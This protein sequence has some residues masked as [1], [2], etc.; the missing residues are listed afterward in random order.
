MF[1]SALQKQRVYKVI[2]LAKTVHAE[3]SKR[4]S[5]NKLNKLLL[6]D[7]R[8]KPPSSGS[9]KEIKIKYVTQVKTNPP[10]FAFFVNEPKLVE[11]KYKRFLEGRLRQHFG[12]IGVPVQLYFRNKRA[13]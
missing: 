4:I 8:E 10:A 12:F 3:Q 13:N 2:E 1:I 7:I 5:T 11:E 6:D 9:G